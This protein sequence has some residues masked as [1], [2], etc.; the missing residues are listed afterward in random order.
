[1]GELQNCNDPPPTLIIGR[2]STLSRHLRARIFGSVLISSRDLMADPNLLV[3]HR[4]TTVRIV[5]NAFRPATKLRDTAERELYVAQSML[6]LGRALDACR[7]LQVERFIY[8]SSA[9]VY[10]DNAFSHEDDPLHPLGIHAALKFAAEQLVRRACEED[11]REYT[12]VRLF[13]MYGGDDRFSV[14]GKLIEAARTGSVFTVGNKGVAAR[15]Y[16]HIDDV[17]R[18]YKNLLDT[19]VPPTCVNVATGRAVSVR[20]LL[21]ALELHGATIKTKHVTTR[22]IALSKACVDRLSEFIDPQSFRKVEEYMVKMI[23]A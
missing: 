21:A 19:P 13:N 16:V 5:F 20:E 12:V 7:D 15:D 4:G 17:V 3:P 2:E 11:G 8:T 6:P 9:S 1:M 22:E 10:G 18:S 14:I 23:L